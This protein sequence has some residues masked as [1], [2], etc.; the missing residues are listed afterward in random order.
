MKSRV[1]MK[2]NRDIGGYV[3][4]KQS[5]D[6]TEAM[7]IKTVMFGR[8]QFDR[9]NKTAHTNK[10]VLGGQISQQRLDDRPGDPYSQPGLPLDPK[11]ISSVIDS[12]HNRS[13]DLQT[14]DTVF[15]PG[16]APPHSMARAKLGLSA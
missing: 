3:K 6:C 1:Q 12:W 7:V 10:N 2:I 15:L 5:S 11:S 16:E 14:L 9:R 4:D 8:H 13:Y